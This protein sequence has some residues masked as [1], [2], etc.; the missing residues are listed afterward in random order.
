MNLNEVLLQP[1]WPNHVTN[2]IL[3][4]HLCKP[5]WPLGKALTPTACPDLSPRS[6][7]SQAWIGAVKELNHLLVLLQGQRTDSL[8]CPVVR[9]HTT[10][11]GL[12]GRSSSLMRALKLSTA[13]GK[14]IVFSVEE[15]NNTTLWN[16][17]CHLL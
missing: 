2:Q 5:N 8:V 11:G 3:P 4:N 9:K 6:L 14:I 12:S 15:N 10:R 17:R 7:F 1:W 16:G 13:L